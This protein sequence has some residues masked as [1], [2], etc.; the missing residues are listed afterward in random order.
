VTLTDDEL[1]ILKTFGPSRFEPRQIHK[2]LA[3]E[4][5]RYCSRCHTVK[6]IG[7]FQ[8][9]ESGL[10]PVCRPCAPKRAADYYKKHKDEIKTRSAAYRRAAKKFAAGDHPEEE[11]VSDLLADDFIGDEDDL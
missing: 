2:R 11:P 10:S 6:A 3:E 1:H 7:D 8:Q 9:F 5:L 4:N